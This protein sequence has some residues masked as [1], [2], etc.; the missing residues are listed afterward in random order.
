[1]SL[2]TLLLVS[3]F[4]FDRII[5]QAYMNVVTLSVIFLLYANNP[6]DSVVGA[7]KKA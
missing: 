7:K 5:I 2:H 3:S 6:P 4:R 1:M